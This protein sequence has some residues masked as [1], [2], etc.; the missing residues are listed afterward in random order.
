MVTREVSQIRSLPCNAANA[1]DHGERA[2]LTLFIPKKPPKGPNSYFYN[3][4]L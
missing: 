1:T 4:R 2:L 3:I